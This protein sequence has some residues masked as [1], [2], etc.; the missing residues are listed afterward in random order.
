[1]F[2]LLMFSY[3][4]IITNIIIKQLDYIGFRDALLQTNPLTRIPLFCGGWE[5]YVSPTILHGVLAVFNK[6]SP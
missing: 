1:M 3:R 2:K 4:T 6:K 5:G